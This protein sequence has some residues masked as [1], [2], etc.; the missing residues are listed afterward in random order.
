MGVAWF[1]VAVAAAWL[2]PWPTAVVFGLVAGAAGF[3]VAAAWR[4]ARVRPNQLGAGIGALVI[5]LAAGIGMGLAA[6]VG[7]AL[8]A[9]AFGLA[10]TDSK[11][12]VPVVVSA[13]A[14]VRG[15]DRPGRLLRADHPDRVGVGLRDW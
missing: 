12:R 2:G 8:I 1:F 5:V 4:R 15:H 3:Q 13:A 11:R 10:A 6:L 14:T 7:L 9:V